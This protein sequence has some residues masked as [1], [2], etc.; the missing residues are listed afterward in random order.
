MDPSL[1]I[2]T[3]VLG[4]LIGHFS[5]VLL[6]TSMLMRNIVWLRAFAIAAAVVKIVYR[7]NFAYDHVSVIWEFVLITVNIGQLALMWW[8]DRRA[9]FSADDLLFTSTVCPGL[10]PNKA[11]KLLNAGRWRE[12]PEGEVLTEQGRPVPELGFLSVGAVR[13]ERDGE[14]VAYCR[15]GDF[16]GE[17]S[18]VT[19]GAAT[20]RAIAATPIR[21]LALDRD[22]TRAL[23]QRD[24][25]INSALQVSFNRNLIDK[26]VKTGHRPAPVEMAA[27]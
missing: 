26:L 5:Y 19:G 20:A 18:F 23:M 4:D 16:L 10:P 12:A 3:S 1:F 2:G 9:A 17:M 24:P 27:T 7:L 21:Y 15:S 8:L 6:V 13:I 11:R 14:T 25:A 22:K